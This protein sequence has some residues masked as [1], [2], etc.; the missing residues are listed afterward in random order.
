MEC[1]VDLSPSKG[2][3][4]GTRQRVPSDRLDVVHLANLEP[5]MASCLNISA[6]Y[7]EAATRR[8]PRYLVA[9]LVD[10]LDGEPCR[11]AP[12]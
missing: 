7:S 11:R 8:V 12:A 6:N 9:V 2:A 4:A 1:N 5:A 10:H 3:M